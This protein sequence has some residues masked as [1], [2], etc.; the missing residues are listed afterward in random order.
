MK[1]T[2]LFIAAIIIGSASY[3]Q[4]EG[5]ENWTLE[6]V[7]SLDDYQSAITNEG[8][9]G[10][11][12]VFQSTDAQ[13]NTKS[14]RLEALIGSDGDTIF[15]YFYSGDV[16][17]GIPGQ[18]T[19]FNGV[20]S[21]VGYYKYDIQTGDSCAI[22]AQTF[23]AGTLSGGGIFHISAGQ[24]TTWKRF[25]YAMNA[26][27]SDSLM[28]AATVGDP[29]NDFKGKPGTWIQFDDVKL[30]KGVQEANIVNGDFENWSSIT[31]DDLTYWKTINE[32]LIG[33]P[34][35]PVVKSTDKYSGTY[36]L[37]LNNVIVPQWGD[38]IEG[39]ITNGDF[40]DNGS[41]GGVP[42]TDSPTSVECYYKLT[43]SGAYLNI[44]FRQGGSV[45]ANAGNSFNTPQTNY[46]YWSQ[47]IPAITP[48]TLLISIGVDRGVGNQFIIDDLDFVF[49]VGISE[50]LKVEKLVAYP[51]PVTDELK[52]KFH[53]LNDNNVSIRLVD[54]VGKEL[55]TRNLGELAAGEYRERFNT[56]EFSTGV[57]FIEFTLGNEKMV[58]RFIVK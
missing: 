16:E 25:A 26:I 40:S 57:Y 17:N 45:V 39:H 32:K 41:I 30:K 44:E 31:W 46:T 10:S 20:D 33:E 28:I 58:D 38:T 42:Y 34:N 6:S 52:I 48:D 13:R 27:T 56:S 47:A 49:P 22:I 9:E 3:A 8:I 2:L 1:K 54:A 18:A 24:Q 43:G 29:L 36:A 51:N 5:F 55:T 12:A 21:L 11:N 50:Q 37:E 35:K 23:M 7:L 53:L 19:P 14:I 15:G 4:Y